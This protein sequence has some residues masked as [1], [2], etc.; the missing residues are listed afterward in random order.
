M[1]IEQ[2]DHVLEL[3]R[4]VTS[5]SIHTTQTNWKLWIICQEDKS[6]SLTYPS[7]S[8]RKYSGSGYSSFAA[9]VSRFSE[10]RQ[11]PGILQLERLN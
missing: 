8:K 5:A 1:N 11:L 6:E 2:L 4:P 9:N 3:E 7:K 10:L